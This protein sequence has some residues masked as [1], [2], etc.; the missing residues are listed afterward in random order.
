MGNLMA[1]VA[2]LLLRR[3][4]GTLILSLNEIESAANLIQGKFSE[5]ILNKQPKSKN[6]IIRYK[7]MWKEFLSC[8]VLTHPPP[9]PQVITYKS[10]TLPYF[11]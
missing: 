2:G 1:A 3:V 11:L 9:R 6:L 4:W 8:L 5:N 10:Q 7:E